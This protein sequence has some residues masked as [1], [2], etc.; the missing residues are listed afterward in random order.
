MGTMKNKAL[1]V[2]AL[3]LSVMMFL[4]GCGI[5]K[6][7]DNADVL[8]ELNSRIIEKVIENYEDGSISASDIAI[9]CIYFGSFSQ[10]NVS[11]MFVLCKLLNT[12]HTAGLDKTTGILL[13]TDS[14]EMT[15]Y[16]EFG[17][18][19][20]VINCI[21]T[22][23]GQSRI[24]VLK[25]TTYQG[26]TTQ[27]IQLLAIEGGQWAE[28]PIDALKT[29]GE[30]AFYYIDIAEDL[31]I[32]TSGDKL[33]EEI[34]AVL[35]WNPETEQ[36]DVFRMSEASGTL[37]EEEIAVFNTE[38]FNGD[39]T[40]MNNM[41]LSGEYSQPDEINLFQLFYNGIL[42][43]SNQVSE[44]ELS[45]LAELCGD[46]LYLDVIKVTA[47]EMDA[48]LQ[49]KMGIGLEET[50]KT[51]LDSFYYLEQYDSYYLVAGDTN[52][53]WCTVT[54]G[55]WESDN[56]LTLEYRKEYEDGQWTVTLQK[57]DADY[58]FISNQRT[59]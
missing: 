19:K 17:A 14:L 46:A 49:E 31:I 1:P 9:D 23:D 28:I 37:S 40:N 44:N 58:L 20:V 39:T 7:G 29:M 59:D 50:K 5:S 54:S 18:D 57:T 11:E 10:D 47:D 34:T 8:S 51:G 36:F 52:F 4:S 43:T 25:S 21:R 2:L 32:V 42:G 27:E 56:Q 16:K 55:A 45:M 41:L 13:E 24:L 38:F 22:S 35:K 33:P 30:E 26:I 48:F 15:A 12:P 6:S 3:A 53:E